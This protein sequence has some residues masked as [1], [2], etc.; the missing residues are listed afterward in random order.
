MELLFHLVS[1]VATAAIATILWWLIQE[2][3]N[4]HD[5]SDRDR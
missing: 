5:G 2:K 3:R 1:A 4:G